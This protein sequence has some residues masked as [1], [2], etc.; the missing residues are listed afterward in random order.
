MLLGIQLMRENSQPPRKRAAPSMACMRSAISNGTVLFE[1]I[2][3]RSAWMRRLR[4]LIA[5]YVS[6]LGGEDNLSSSE[7]ILV[8]R[9]VEE[10]RKAIVRVPL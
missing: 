6:D 8:R 5:D 1:G 4:D 3:H 10:F 7:M 9:S 2:D